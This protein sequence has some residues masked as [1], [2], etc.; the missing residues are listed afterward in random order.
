MRWVFRLLLITTL[1]LVIYYFAVGPVALI[2]GGPLRGDVISRSVDDW[3]FTDSVA[4]VQLE[5]RD[6]WLPYSVTTWCISHAGNLYIP[7]RNAAGKRWVAN[8]V[9]DA[10][11]RVRIGDSVYERRAVRVT[12]P[13]ES[14]PLMSL[15]L[16]KY[17]GIEVEEGGPIREP[18]GE[19]EARAEIWMFRMDPRA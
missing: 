1:L 3:S 8:V 4:E 14:D 11:V 12:D 19:G 10:R 15:L 13:T 5:T 16:E 7:S 18:A 6:G 9:R 17:L 2:A